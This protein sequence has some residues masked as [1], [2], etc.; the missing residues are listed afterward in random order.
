MRQKEATTTRALYRQRYSGDAEL[1]STE[2]Q[3]R[4]KRGIIRAMTS[5]ICFT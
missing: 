2:Y 3:E 4:S 1:Y 5:E